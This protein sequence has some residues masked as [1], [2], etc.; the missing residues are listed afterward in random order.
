MLQNCDKLGWGGRSGAEW[1]Q[2]IGDSGLEH[3][4]GARGTCATRRKP[5]R[6]H[7]EPPARKPLGFRHQVTRKK[8]AAP[9]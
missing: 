2:G 9:R 5:S 1:G 8:H 7:L 6:H 4:T 3:E